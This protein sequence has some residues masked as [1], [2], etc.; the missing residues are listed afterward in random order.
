MTHLLYI[1]QSDPLNGH[2]LRYS[3]RSVERYLHMGDLHVTIVG[4]KPDWLI[5]VNHVP[6]DNIHSAKAANMAYKTWLGCHELMGVPDP[7]V[8]MEDDSILLD[9]QSGIPPV[10][11]GDLSTHIA[12]I[13][14]AHH[15]GFWMSEALRASL[16]FLGNHPSP[17]SW[18]VHRP[19]PIVPEDAEP[20]IAPFAHS[21]FPALVRSVWGTLTLSGW[22][23]R[24]ARFIG[25]SWPQERG[26][27]WVSLDERVPKSIAT[28]FPTP[29]R[30][31]DS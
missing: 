10:Y 31:E 17:Q 26:P 18:E 24:D 7:V 5:D 12:R 9:H 27:A 14:R 30:W 21:G 2:E 1:Y 29:S 15:R 13:E 3:L 25:N 28:R 8:Y 4:D 6:A 22:E 19:T 11:W 16:R 20:V 23:G